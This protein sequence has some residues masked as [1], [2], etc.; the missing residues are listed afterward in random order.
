MRWTCPSVSLHVSYPELT[1]RVLLSLYHGSG[2]NTLTTTEDIGA[3]VEQCVAA[4]A[5]ASG[6]LR[7]I[8]LCLCALWVLQN[9]HRL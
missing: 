5:V 6:S 2:L 3:F 1:K 4:M 7:R 9:Y 8:L